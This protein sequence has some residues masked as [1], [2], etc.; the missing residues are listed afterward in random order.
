MVRG[1]LTEMG[2]SSWKVW[3]AYWPDRSGVYAFPTEVEALRF[4]ARQGGMEVRILRNGD[5]I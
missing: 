3:V 1:A 4:A 5:G 2:P